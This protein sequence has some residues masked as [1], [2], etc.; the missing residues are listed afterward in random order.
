MEELTRLSNFKPTAAAVAAALLAPRCALRSVRL[1]AN[2]DPNPSPSPSP[3]PNPNQ[4]RLR[5][6]RIGPRGA[7]PLARGLTL[8]LT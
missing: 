8:T 5:A 1:R 7:G 4:V 2:P 3:N 6:N